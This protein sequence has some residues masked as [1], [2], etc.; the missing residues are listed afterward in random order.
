M[1]IITPK[2]LT[3]VVVS[4]LNNYAYYTGNWTE[5]IECCTSY[6]E[7]IVLLKSELRS[8]PMSEITSFKPALLN[9]LIEFIDWDIVSETMMLRYFERTGKPVKF[10]TK[11]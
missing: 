11:E 3:D 7:L 9:Y 10:K 1:N 4:A 8:N 5:K 6:T 2:E